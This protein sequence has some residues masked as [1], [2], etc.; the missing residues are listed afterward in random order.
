MKKFFLLVAAVAAMAV[1]G[2]AFYE[3]KRAV[4]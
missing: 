4:R 2:T 3:K 1:A